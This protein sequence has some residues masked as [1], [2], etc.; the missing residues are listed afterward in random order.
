MTH[1]KGWFLDAVKLLCPTRFD[2]ALLNQGMN[3][4]MKPRVS[5]S[6]SYPKPAMPE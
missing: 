1:Q 2:L 6:S 4:N 3:L 5:R